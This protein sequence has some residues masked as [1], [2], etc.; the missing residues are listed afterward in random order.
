[1]GNILILPSLVVGENTE[2]IRQSSAHDKTS[3]LK[4]V[5]V[6]QSVS[7][8]IKYIIYALTLHL[9]RI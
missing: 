5:E 3:L 8:T 1:M 6:L 4:V 2:Y 7:N 9:G